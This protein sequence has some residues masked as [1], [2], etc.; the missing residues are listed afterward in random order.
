MRPEKCQLGCNRFVNSI[1]ANLPHDKRNTRKINGWLVGSLAEVFPVFD[2]ALPEAA[3]ILNDLAL[4]MQ[5]VGA[6]FS[7]ACED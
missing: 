4:L 2:E 5:G 7:K 1:V 3:H 6:F